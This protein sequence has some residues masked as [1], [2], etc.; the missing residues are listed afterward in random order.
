[1]DPQGLATLA[2]PILTA[3]DYFTKWPEA[4]SLLDQEAET[5]VDALVEGMFSIFGVPEV[6]HT[7]QGSYFESRVFA[8][9]CEKLGSH[10][11][12]TTPLYPQSVNS[13][14]DLNAN[15]GRATGASDG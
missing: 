6:I 9:M 11:T 5:I 10:K 1:M 12:P 13:L 15:A 14:R 8:A 4:Y 7:D 2:S 3:M